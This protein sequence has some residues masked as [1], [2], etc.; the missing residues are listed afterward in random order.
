MSSDG[1][2]EPVFGDPKSMTGDAVPSID[3]GATFA[4]SPSAPFL[5][6][7]E[8]GPD[9]SA[10]LMRSGI[11]IALVL[12]AFGGYKYHLGTKV[13]SQIADHSRTDWTGGPVATNESG[14][15][16]LPTGSNKATR[17]IDLTTTASITSKPEP[18]V[19]EIETIRSGTA[20]KFH[21]VESGDTLSAIARTYEISTTDIMTINK[22]ENPRLIKP[23]MKLF[24]TK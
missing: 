8:P 20:P 12:A 6:E 18:R 3:T 11:V 9:A 17:Q 21:I 1:R 14:N 4:P 7:D 16:I 19:T 5:L 10:I 13:D 2:K 23:G 22:I 15:L 24:V